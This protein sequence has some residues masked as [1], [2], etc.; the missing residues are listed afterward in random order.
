MLYSTPLDPFV[1]QRADPCILKGADGTYYFTAS[2]PEYDRIILRSSS[3]LEGLK[4]AEE[5]VLWRKRETGI[6]SANIWAPEIHYYDEAWYIYFAA[7]ETTVTRDGLFNHR[8]Y[9]LENTSEDPMEGE[10]VEKG[11][12]RTMWESFA[13]DATHWEYDGN[14]YLIWAQKDPDIEGNSNLYISLMANPWTLTGPAVML[15]TPEFEWEKIGFLVNEGPAVITHEGRV[16]ITYSAS[17][18]DHNYCVGVLS[19]SLS[20]Y[21]LD[22]DSWTKSPKPILTTD[23][24]RPL[25][26]PGHNS[27]TQDE[28]GEDIFVFHARTYMEIEGDP[29]YDPNRHCYLSYIVWNENGKLQIDLDRTEQEK[30]QS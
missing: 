20:S 2:V 26:G 15:S 17:A 5:K 22:P 25:Y 7:A 11:Q 27:V 6:L 21:L 28:H 9:V 12:L 1:A 24:E 14:H 30:Q 29:L 19:A 18:T 10:W 4:Q 16:Y 23:P 8:I 3:T 13:L